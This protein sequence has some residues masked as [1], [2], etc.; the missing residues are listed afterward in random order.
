MA[1]V[2]PEVEI[3]RWQAI[4]EHYAEGMT[5]AAMVPLLRDAGLLDCQKGHR[6]RRGKNGTTVCATCENTATQTWLRGLA[7]LGEVEANALEVRGAWIEDH[8]FIIRT[9]RERCI[10]RV[11]ITTTRSEMVARTV[12]VDGVETV[13]EVPSTITTVREE[14]R[15]NQGLLR[16]L[17][18][19]RDKITRMT[20]IDLDDPE[21]MEKVPR[22]KVNVNRSGPAAGSGERPV[23]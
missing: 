21:A 22:G 16:L 12:T 2:V 17:S 19:T 11:R 4:K 7:R 20:G 3:D 10:Q 18:E 15:I 6:Q 8:E 1:D 5:F 9:C 23:N 14:V 13:S